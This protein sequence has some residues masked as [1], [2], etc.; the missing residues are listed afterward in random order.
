MSHKLLFYTETDQKTPE[1]YGIW[2]ELPGFT[3]IKAPFCPTLPLHHIPHYQKQS[4][5]RRVPRDPLATSAL[6]QDGM[7][8]NCKS[9]QTEVFIS[10]ALGHITVTHGYPGSSLQ[11]TQH[12]S[13][14]GQS[15]EAPYFQYRNPCTL[16]HSSFMCRLDAFYFTTTGKMY[17]SSFHCHMFARGPEILKILNQFYNSRKV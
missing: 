17:F 9:G 7:P 13:I 11:Y 12:Y 10:S 4:T 8:S 6:R 3:L 1:K 15:I 5:A 14:E 16:H 2:K